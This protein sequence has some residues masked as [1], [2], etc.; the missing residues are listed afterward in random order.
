MARR[1]LPSTSARIFKKKPSIVS[2]LISAGLL[3]LSLL[4]VL[5]GIGTAVYLEDARAPAPQ[6]QAAAESLAAPP[7]VPAP[8]QQATAE[9]PSPP[10]VPTLP[11]PPPHDPL[12]AAAAPPSVPAPAPP[13]VTPAAPRPAPVAVESVPPAPAPETATS[14]ALIEPQA[15]EP[16]EP[17]ADAGQ[18][19]PSETAPAQPAAPAEAAAPST[20][21][22]AEP[23]PAYW[24][25]YGVYVGKTYAQRLKQKLA[26]QGLESVVVRTR[27][28][29][30][31]PLL[32]VR[33]DHVTHAA[34]LAASETAHR[35]LKIRP[36]IH[37]DHR[38]P[39]SAAG[40][41]VASAAPRGYWVQYGA[42]AHRHNAQRLGH[43]LTR[44]GLHAKV[45]FKRGTSG[46]PLYL[47][48]SSGLPDRASAA[49]LAQRYR[50]IAAAGVL[51]G[52]SRGLHG[53]HEGATSRQAPDER[54][55][56]ASQRTG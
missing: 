48:R 35:A 52:H 14:L 49:Q 33:S 38:V 46:K 45:Y 40:I 24:V 2:R 6:Q 7:A 21:P 42:F 1:K 3:T 56:P 16:A 30:G 25:E 26:E 12:A 36:L 53:R 31:R 22:S 17:A 54:Q 41:A 9:S 15:G 51:I 47:V 43:E 27:T 50:Q 44:H 28:P 20:L 5:V 4:V 18:T 55:R 10:A 19:A 32:R 8:Q 34:A 13:A 11:A 39:P 37:R 23:P 29:A